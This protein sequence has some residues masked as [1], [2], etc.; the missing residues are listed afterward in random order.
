MILFDG[1]DIKVVGRQF[2]A[3]GGDLV[4]TFTGRAANPPV[5]KGFGETYLEKRG[6]SAIHFISKKNHWWQ[7]PETVE[8]LESLRASGVFE[9]R[10]LTLYGSSMGGY[11]AMRFSRLLQPY[12]VVVFSPQFSIDAAKVP[13]ETRWRN[14]AAKLDFAADNMAEGIDPKSR[15]L[16]L[17]DPMFRPDAKHVALFEALRPVERVI[18]PFAGHNT[19]RLLSEVGIITAVT[20]SLIQGGFDCRQFTGLYRRERCTGALFWHGLAETLRA[21]RRPGAAVLAALASVRLLL[22]LD[23]MHDRTL[24]LDILHSGLAAALELGRLDL[25]QAMLELATKLDAA[26]ARSLNAQ[27]A[28]ARAIGRMEDAHRLAETAAN[29]HPNDLAAMV[30]LASILT[31]LGRTEQAIAIL[32]RLPP[33]LQGAPPVLLARARLQVAAEQWEDAKTTL[34]RFCRL[35]GRDAEARVLLARCWARTGRPDA[36]EVQLRPLLS[37]PI[38]SPRLAREAVLLL[39]SGGSGALAVSTANLHAK[40]NKACDII[41]AFGEERVW[42]DDPHMI[43]RE[44]RSAVRSAV[45]GA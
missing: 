41:T 20:G 30:G 27:A 6:I 40:Y 10:R 5:E 32:D 9:G 24:R 1:N 12:Q 13:F 37:A 34:R 26:S 21:H 42:S 17:F 45:S 8:A 15:M 38:V 3:T 43:V 19:A 33:K 7:T 18:I 11:A 35:E 25:A 14:Y 28:V 22:K 29:S 16:V 4:I 36:A 39:E 23:R 44:V 2:Q 31:E